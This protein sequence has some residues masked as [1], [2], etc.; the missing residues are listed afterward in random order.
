MK[1]GKNLYFSNSYLKEIMK[2]EHDSLPPLPFPP[3]EQIS[4]L[5]QFFGKSECAIFQM[6]CQNSKLQFQ[7]DFFALIRVNWLLTRT[8]T[9]HFGECRIDFYFHF[10]LSKLYQLFLIWSIWKIAYDCEIFIK[11]DGILWSKLL[12][13]KSVNLFENLRTENFDDWWFLIL[14]H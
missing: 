11:N 8:L 14:Q 3:I 4:N 10:V 6:F 13:K 9:M 1:K 12:S 2:I 5:L 7:P